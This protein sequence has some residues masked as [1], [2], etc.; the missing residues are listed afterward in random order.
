MSS[1]DKRLLGKN[2]LITGAGSGI[3]RAIALRYAR[4]GANV[5][6]NDVAVDRAESTAYEVEDLGVKSIV[7]AADVSDSEQV[8]A[9]VGQ[10]YAEWGQLD[11]LVNN[12]GIGGSM[13]A[14]TMMKEDT[15]D[16]TINTNLRSVFLVSKYAAK[17]MVK[18]K[19][20]DDQLRGKIINMAAVR[21]KLGRANF[22]AYS[23]AKFG[24]VSLTQTMALELGKNRIT[25]NAICPGL[26]WTPIYGNTTS[27]NLAANN[28]PPALT[29]KPVGMPEDVAG[30]AFFLASSDSDWITG[31]SLL[32]CGGQHF[33]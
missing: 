23:A 2:T 22:G 18:A 27:E 8:Q 9:M 19:V 16:R 24:V 14:V 6:V 3:G 11:V 13:E 21:G 32:V 26:I 10:Y 20:P 5:A 31:Q 12:A 7:L 17:R 4:E 28:P 15:W 1:F 30:A 33:T 29:Y 25:V